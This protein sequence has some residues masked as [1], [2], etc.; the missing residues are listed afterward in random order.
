M[1]IANLIDKTNFKV[2]T[3]IPGTAKVDVETN[4]NNTITR[5]QKLFLKN[6]LG[7]ALYNDFDAGLAAN[8]TKYEELRDGKTYQVDNSEGNEV[9]V[10]W[11]GLNVDESFLVYFIFTKYVELNTKRFTG[12]AMVRSENQNSEL[13]SLLDTIPSVWNVGLDLYGKPFV[14][15]ST[16]RVIYPKFSDLP[17]FPSIVPDNNL[18]NNSLFNFIWHMRDQNGDDYYPNWVFTDLGNMNSLNI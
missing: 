8:T 15:I 14:P 12:N 18:I 9:D 1:A 6:A 3:T 13:L 10:V 16:N 4:L 11:G 2:D 17:F 7:E 5:Y